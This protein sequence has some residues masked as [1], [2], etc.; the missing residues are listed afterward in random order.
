MT[1]E[2]KLKYADD[3]LNRLLEWTRTYG[4]HLVPKAG[5]IDTYGDGM[6]EAK[7]MVHRILIGDLNEKTRKSS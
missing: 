2:E 4:T 3:R 6:R 5:C 7:N 1:T